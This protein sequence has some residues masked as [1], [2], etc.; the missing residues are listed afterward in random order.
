MNNVTM[1]LNLLEETDRNLRYLTAKFLTFL[2]TNKA[3]QIISAI[4]QSPLGISRIVDL[5]RTKV[6]MIRNGSMKKEKKESNDKR[7]LSFLD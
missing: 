5:L 1:I 2:I 6:D 3:D 7:C 4:L